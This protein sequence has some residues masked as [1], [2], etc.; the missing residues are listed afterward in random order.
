MARVRGC[1]PPAGIARLAVSAAGCSGTPCLPRGAIT[2]SSVS[3]ATRMGCLSPSP[4]SAKFSTVRLPLIGPCAAALCFSIAAA[5]DLLLTGWP[6][7]A[8]AALASGAT[9]AYSILPLTVPVATSP[10][11]IPLR[12]VRSASSAACTGIRLSATM[13]FGSASPGS[14]PAR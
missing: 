8:P 10:G 3:L 7:A 2:G 5:G 4:L 13:S 1:A 9:P 6:L 11:P 14:S 12:T